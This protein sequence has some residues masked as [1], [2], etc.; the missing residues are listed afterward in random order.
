M[1]YVRNANTIIFAHH[2]LHPD[3]SPVPVRG[4]LCMQTITVGDWN[5]KKKKVFCDI[6]IVYS[7][8]SDPYFTVGIQLGSLIRN[9]VM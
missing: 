2:I 6:G 3:S 4:V 5:I 1:L 7:C 8:R 9:P